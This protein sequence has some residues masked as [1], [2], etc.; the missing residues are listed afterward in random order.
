MSNHNRKELKLHIHGMHCA[1]CEVLIERNFKKVPGVEQVN[2]SQATGKARLTYSKPP[3]LKALQAVVQ[4][5]GYTVS[6]WADRHRVAAQ[7]E[8]RNTQKDYIELGAV[9]LVLVAGYLILRQFDLV[10]KLGVTDNM[11]YGLVFALGLVAA[12]STCLAVTGGLLVAV[13]GK[14]NQQHPDLTGYQKFKPTIYFNAGR[15]VSYTVLGGAVGALG[16][17]LTLSPRFNGL[18]TIAASLV[19]IVL[20]CQLLK[21]FPGLKRFQPK[22]PKFLA[23]KI[24]DATSNAHHPAAP[25]LLGAATFF[26]PCGFTQALQLYVLSKGDPITGALTMLVFSLGTLPA[27]MSLSAIA[28]FAKGAFQRYFL[29]FSG[30]LVIMLG[31]FNINNGLTLAGSS[32]NLSGLWQRSDTGIAQAADPNVQ[33]VDGK[34]VVDMTV[35]GLRYFPHQFTVKQG[36]PVEWRIDGTRA[37][38]CAQV[39]TVPKLGITKYL[40][41]SGMTTVAFTPTE[42]G[43]VPFSCTMGMTTR[44]SAFTVVPNDSPAAAQ[45]AQALEST[46]PQSS[47]CDPAISNCVSAQ[48]LK[49][50]VTAE[51]GFYPNTFAVKKGVPV[52]LLLDAK[53]PLGGCMSVAVIPQYNVAQPLKLGVNK[54]AFTP[55]QLGPVDMTCSMGI[56]MVRF[57]VT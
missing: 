14:Y 9:V 37:E 23:H 13:A 25:F 34:Q 22:M 53:V 6:S 21:L 42:T 8:H 24:H 31:L 7:A 47:G 44:G 48:Q 39:I 1:S 36:I 41:A 3:D 50:E 11:S 40:S 12:M 4:K 29:K 51:R 33:L 26:L 52:E 43:T 2:V 5:H 30:A 10:P 38:G 19:M 55:T 28:S 35:S 57:N 54:I 17:V 45:P 49:L 27:L 15:V 56:P 32:V 46:T 16:S 20:G 18:M